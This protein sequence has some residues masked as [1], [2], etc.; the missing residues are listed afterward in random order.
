LKG[1]VWRGSVHIGQENRTPHDATAEED[2][3]TAE[4]ALAVGPSNFAMVAHA[5][6][7][8]TAWGGFCVIAQAFWAGGWKIA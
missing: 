5:A 6:S 2:P 1:K 4:F 3:A 8:K 7:K